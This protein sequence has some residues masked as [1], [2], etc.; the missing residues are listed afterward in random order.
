M[1]IVAVAVVLQ[2]VAAPAA[3]APVLAATASNPVI[4][5]IKKRVFV[6]QKPGF[7]IGF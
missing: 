5:L 4:G 3:P 6:A 7:L 1:A 2:A